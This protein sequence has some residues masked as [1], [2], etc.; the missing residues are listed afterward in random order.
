MNKFRK[1]QFLALGLAT[2]T[3]AGIFGYNY[4]SVQKAVKP[5][6]IV[7]T[8]KEIPGHTKITEDMVT[9]RT[10]PGD[11]IPPNA[12]KNIKDVVGKYTV[13]GFGIPANS[14]LFQGKVLPKDQM[15]DAAVLNLKE[16][17]VAFPL[18][19]DI[20][21]SSGNSIVPGTYVDLYFMKKVDEQKTLIDK[22]QEKVIFGGLFQHVRVT[23]AKDQDTYDVFHEENKD[24]NNDR[25]RITRLYT[26]AV[27]PEQYQYLERAKKLG[28]I[29]PLATGLSNE[30]DIAHMKE[31]Y[32][33]S[34]VSN[35]KAVLDYIEQNSVNPIPNEV[36][37]KL[38]PKE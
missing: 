11:A 28:E 23:A 1:N 16:G 24:D 10:I 13:D 34:V 2:L 18:L 30:D 21:T 29:I 38:N 9:V 33:F 6:K 17:E 37:Q 32:N 26:F 3:V 15:A 7:M 5:T 31:K 12:I 4:F 22:K 36:K 14:Y 27:T 35:Q 20:E 19:V 25:K 8:V